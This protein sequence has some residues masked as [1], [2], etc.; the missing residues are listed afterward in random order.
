MSSRVLPLGP[1]PSDYFEHPR[2]DLVARLPR[3]LGRVLDVG[4]GA[5]AVGGSL[6]AA[7]AAELVGIERDAAAAQRARATFDA[8]WEGDVERLLEAPPDAA[9]FDTVCCYDILEHLYDPAAVAW[10]LRTMT[11]RGGHLH[12]SIPNARH[13]SLF[14]DLVVKGTFG[15]RTFGH[16]DVTHIRWFTRRDIVTLLEDCGWTVLDVATHRFPRGRATITALSGGTARDYFAVQ[17]YVLC[18]A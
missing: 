14:L 1:K 17:W 5:G 2:A 9:K 18:R 10:R 6:R 13:L 8:V 4:C 16:R 15:Y 11:V 12:V 7:G 3:P